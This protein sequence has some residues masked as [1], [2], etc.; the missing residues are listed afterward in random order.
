MF[1][2]HIT[3]SCFIVETQS[4]EITL[5]L[6]DRHLGLHV[7]FKHISPGSKS[8]GRHP[9][10]RT[11]IIS[12]SFWVTLFL[13][14]GI[15]K[16]ILH[17]SVTKAGEGNSRTRHRHYT[18]THTCL[19]ELSAII[20]IIRLYKSVLCTY[21]QHCLGKLL[22]ITPVFDDGLAKSVEITSTPHN[23]AT[24]VACLPPC[25]LA[26]SSFQQNQNVNLLFWARST[27]LGLNMQHM[28]T[29]KICSIDTRQLTSP[30]L[31]TSPFPTFSIYHLIYTKSSSWRTLLLLLLLLLLLYFLYQY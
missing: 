15:C 30:T 7:F 21:T 25:T 1:I 22:L 14:R 10:R 29:R 3:Y 17:V 13:F 24:A 11:S 26:Q 31:T 19:S 18:E 23:H 5:N 2:Q 12:F 28:L 4:T 6:T 8:F 20:W 16:T 27:F 9:L